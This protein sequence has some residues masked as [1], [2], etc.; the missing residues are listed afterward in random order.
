[1][2]QGLSFLLIFMLFST[3]I[4][5]CIQTE[6]TSLVS[7][8]QSLSSPSFNWTSGN[9]CHWEGITC[10]E[11]GR[12]TNLSLSS[13][14]LKLQGDIF[15]PSSLG[16][17]THLTYLNLSHNS[18]SGVLSDR[19]VNLAN[20]A[21]LDLRFN[22]FR[23][24]LPLHFGK[25]SKL[26]FLLLQFNNF[27]GSLPQ[28]LMNCTNLIELNLGVNHFE[29]DISTY[30]FSKLSMLSR[31]D[32]LNNQ[33]TGTFP[34]SL[35]SCKSL[36]AIRFRKN[37]IGGQIQPEILSL[38]SL[39]FLALSFNRLTNITGAMRILM[40]CESL[41][42]LCFSSSFEE[43]VPADFGLAGSDG[44]QNLRFLDLSG[45]H[46]SGPI[47]VWLSKLKNLKI[48]NLYSNKLTGTIPSLLGTL[49][50]LFY[51][52]LSFNLISGYFPKQ[53]C[54]LPMLVSEQTA[55]NVDHHNY[56]ELAIYFTTDGGKTTQYNSFTFFPPSIFLQGNNIN[57]T[58]P[59]EIGQL[60]LLRQLRLANNSISGTIPD[61]I[62]NL[63]N[64]EV[65]DLS[66][67]HLSGEIPASFT[68]LNFLSR[69][70][71][72]YNNLQG[73]IPSSTQL[74]SFDASA[75]EG[76]PKLC[77]APLPNECQTTADSD[78]ADKNNQDADMMEHQ[79]PWFYFSVSLG[80]IVGFWGV[81]GPV[82][83]MNK[84]KYLDNVAERIRIILNS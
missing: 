7:F 9:C 20:L 78:A 73:P 61:Q 77:G 15:P 74:Q 76:N 40:H 83:L 64:M 6:R 65:L 3:H 58:I 84:W 44:F 19:I 27:T 63:K 33:F 57:G 42:F 21:I 48:L 55:A 69:F 50:K 36:K 24:M 14:D 29:G 30:N 12:V 26:K 62:S 71:V 35:Y 53:L 51:I 17:L 4:H 31:L 34:T 37:D 59:I 45:C 46:L 52:D 16:N 5:A 75:F 22:N 54:R 82:L 2:D 66:M 23:G 38:K 68:S 39:S 28:S 72:S 8:A 25:L 18:L 80:F 60:R 13:K 11:A 67:N 79:I 10:N 70:D 49:P 56:L 47:P 32:I 41:I 1:M 81:C 43:Q